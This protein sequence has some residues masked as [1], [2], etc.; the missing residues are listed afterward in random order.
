MITRGLRLIVISAALIVC[1]VFLWTGCFRTETPSVDKILDRYV[2][3]I[4][5]KAVFDK[6]TTRVIQAT[7]ETP[8]LSAPASM[9]VRRKAPN[10]TWS[11]IDAGPAG[12]GI[13][14]CDGTVAWAKS[15]KGVTEKTGEELANAL[16]EATFND[17]ALRTTYPD[18][19]FKGTEKMGDADVYLLESNPSA[20]THELFYFDVK[21]GLNVRR[22]SEAQVGG[23]AQKT[24][25]TFADFR[26][27]DGVKEPFVV[28]ILMFVSGKLAPSM[29][30]KCQSV[31]HNVPLDD[32]IFKKP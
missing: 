31:K 30:I 32:E 17:A 5:G 10:K 18:L 24:E 25:T 14:G 1:S 15:P 8:M 19:K 23:K 28:R 20:S 11:K 22:D 3:A 27:V 13:E 29:T 2:Q 12:E 26:D 6:M 7:L 21:T 9:E 16:R 4:G